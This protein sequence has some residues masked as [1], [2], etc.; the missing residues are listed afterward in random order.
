MTAL[1]LI[2]PDLAAIQ[3]YSI[4]ND[5]LDCPLH[6]NELPWSPITAGH[7]RLN[8]YPT[9]GPKNQLQNQLASIYQI[10]HDELMLTRGSDEGIDLL[11]RLFLRSGI[12]NIMQCPPT[13]S[14]YTFYARLQQASIISCPLQENDEGFSLNLKKI[15]TLWKPNCKLIIL[16]RPNNPTGELID[17]AT[18]STLCEQYTNQSI[19]IVDEAYIEFSDTPSATTLINQFDNLIVLRTLSKAYGL[20]GLR[21]GAVIAKA[22]MIEALRKVTA[23]FTLSNTVIELGITALQNKT[24]FLNALHCITQLRESLATQLQLSPWVDKVYPSTAN[25]ILIKTPYALAL[26]DWFNQN[27]I[28]IRSFADNPQLQSHLRITVGHE[29]QNKQLLATL[30]SFAGDKS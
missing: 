22:S 28:A 23:P 29:A 19:I 8:R 14:M 5:E 18:I 4:G 11:M 1:N 9:L 16:C 10:K 7:T 2:R 30:A 20:A 21:L 3:T 13:F 6:A 27:N 15:N 26:S 25:F 12:D 17:L 24:W